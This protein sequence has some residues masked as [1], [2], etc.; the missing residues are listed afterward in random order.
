MVVQNGTWSGGFSSESLV[1]SAL[2]SRQ[3]TRGYLKQTM[4]W[5]IFNGSDIEDTSISTTLVEKMA[6]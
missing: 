4:V 2:N 3:D 5:W 6:H 1:G